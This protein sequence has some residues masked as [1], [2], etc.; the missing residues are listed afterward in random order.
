L[1]I[2]HP[3]KDG[4]FKSLTDNSPDITAILDNHLTYI[5]INGAITKY[6]GLYPEDVIGKDIYFSYRSE[7][8]SRLMLKQINNAIATKEV[9]ELELQINTLLGLRFFNIRISA[10]FNEKNNL[11]NVFLFSRDISDLRLNQIELENKEKYIV[12]STEALLQPFVI[13][14]PIYEDEIITDFSY[15]YTN[16]AAVIS[17]GISRDRMLSDSLL[18]LFPLHN[19]NGVFESFRKVFLTGE[20][21]RETIYYYGPAG[22]NKMQGVFEISA[23]KVEKALVVTWNDIT[24]LKLTEDK[25]L[26]SEK[27][28]NQAF[29]NSPAAMVISKTNGEFID[30]N[31][32]YEIMFGFTRDELIGKRSVD[33]GVFIDPRDRDILMKIMK[34]DGIVKNQEFEL[35]HKSQG[36][37]KALVSVVQFEIDEELFFLS[38]IL[39]ITDQ[40]R[41]EM[42]LKDSLKEKTILLQEVHHRVRNNMQ[43]ILSMLN[44]QRNSNSDTL[45]NDQ[46][47]AAQNRIRS[48]ALVYDK[49]FPSDSYS[50][51]NLKTYLS[52]LLTD[53]SDTLFSPEVK[54]NF[55]LKDDF[56]MDIESAIKIGL[57]INE[58]YSNSFKHAFPEISQGKINI[59]IK[60]IEKDSLH[61]NYS[62]NGIGITDVINASKPGSLG[63]RLINILV[64]DLNGTISYKRVKDYTRFEIL[65]KI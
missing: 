23:A 38:V 58:L 59:D 36:I 10:V 25:L 54:L 12:T 63:L 46:L 60:Q 27:K 24:N 7:E 56:S 1:K 55:H 33:T 31:K 11:K 43:I 4:L 28:F 51:I 14:N 62:D 39:D 29:N 34:R 40:R 19:E 8:N 18:N 26:K 57:I 37:I 17:N 64:D 49:L 48:M 22:S 16:E 3:A 52:S 30:V 42:S 20:P 13:L 21:W 41:L 65:I 6:T 61:I 47:L 35:R 5:Y 45:L 44:L 15:S 53:T 50:T 2:I 9:T 32:A